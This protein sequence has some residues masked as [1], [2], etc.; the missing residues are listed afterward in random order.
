MNLMQRQR[1]ES[2]AAC[3]APPKVQAPWK[4]RPFHEELDKGME[5]Q[6]QEQLKARE[7]DLYRSGSESMAEVAARKEQ[8]LGVG[9]SP[10]RR[11]QRLRA[12]YAMDQA[13]MA[14]SRERRL[15]SWLELADAMRWRPTDRRGAGRQQ[16]ASATEWLHQD[17]PGLKQA[18]RL[19]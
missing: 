1:Q 13:E 2:L 17:S 4:D 11:D 10:K 14:D 16:T 8:L 7:A 18:G 12:I 5:F 19:G 6:T 9:E 3:P 15:N